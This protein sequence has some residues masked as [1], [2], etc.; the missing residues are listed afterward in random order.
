MATPAPAIPV[1]PPST[2]GATPVPL[3]RQ[4]TLMPTASCL[5]LLPILMAL[6]LAAVNYDNNLVYLVLFFVTSITIVAA[7]HTW[8]AL[9]GIELMPGSTWPTFAGDTMRFSVQVHNRT[10]VD[11]HS[12][13]VTI[14]QY[15]GIREQYHIPLVTAQGM[16]TADFRAVVPR[17][18]RHAVQGVMLASEFPLG[19]FRITRVIPILQHYVVYPKAAGTLPRPEVI[20]DAADQDDGHLAGGDDFNGVRTFR[21]GDS[22]RR[23]DWKAVA[24]GRPM[25]VKEFTGAGT[26]RVWFDVNQLYGLT[27]EERLSQIARWILDSEEDECPYGLRIGTISVEP[28]LGEQHRHHCLTLLADQPFTTSSLEKDAS[29]FDEATP[30]G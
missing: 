15:P 3:A 5:I 23:I 20:A 7:V 14:P 24:R 22:Q 25:V 10:H 21:Q 4:K 16:V 11:V 13:W 26:G 6:M 17:R 29:L 19:L 27:T 18:G 28:D 1:L 2:P 9:E 30:G 8:R 12:V